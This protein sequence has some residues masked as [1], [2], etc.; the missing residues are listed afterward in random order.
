[1]SESSILRLKQIWS[2]E[3]ATRRTQRLDKEYL[4][5]W[6]DGIYPKAGPKNVE[7][8]VLVVVGLNRKGRKEI[9]ALEEGYRE[10][11]ESWKEVLRSLKRR[12]VDWIGL[13][14][15]DGSLGLWNALRDIFPHSR[16]QRCFVHKMRN[17]L[18]KI[19]PAKQ[20]EV[21]QAL[22]EM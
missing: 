3:Y 17:I 15:A 10:S 8:A 18:D 19:P 9:L 6:A 22:Q 13:T 7:M 11:A 21:R 5:V 2:K 4:Y 16:R 1:M 20:E 14:I 12:G